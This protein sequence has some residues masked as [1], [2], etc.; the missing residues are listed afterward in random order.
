MSSW[1]LVLTHLRKS[2]DVSSRGRGLNISILLDN[3]IHSKVPLLQKLQFH[4]LSVYFT[5]LIDHHVNW[6]NGGDLLHYFDT[7]SLKYWCYR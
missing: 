1:D 4:Y 6:E 7:K 3:V 5:K 2:F